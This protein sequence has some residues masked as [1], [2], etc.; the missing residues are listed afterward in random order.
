MGV[1]R[2]VNQVRGIINS[3]DME[4]RSSGTPVQQCT[5]QPANKMSGTFVEGMARI[6]VT[7]TTPKTDVTGLSNGHGFRFVSD[8]AETSVSHFAQIGHEQ[9]GS[10]YSALACPI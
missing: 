6:A 2:T 3:L 7:A 8:P 1:N 5:N 10:F 4:W 9:N